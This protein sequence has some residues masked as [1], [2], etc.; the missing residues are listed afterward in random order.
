[1]ET[2]NKS[3]SL[4]NW[5]RISSKSIYNEFWGENIDHPIL[6]RLLAF[7]VD[8]IVVFSINVIPLVTHFFGVVIDI[9]S[10]I[11]LLI[12]LSVSIIYFTLLNSRVGNGQTIGK[13]VFK[14]KVTSEFGKP[15][16]LVKSLLRSLPTTLF[17]HWYLIVFTLATNDLPFR[18]I[19]HILLIFAFGTLYFSVIKLNRQGLHDLLVGTQ[20][21]QKGSAIHTT[22]NLTPRVVLGFVLPVGVYLAYWLIR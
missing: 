21:I 18:Y 16:S 5:L 3:L 8:F 17:I 22:K 6:R 11:I 10:H 20:V 4:K 1:M 13:R 7:I 19:A 12:N 9:E 14:I 15:I 2:Q